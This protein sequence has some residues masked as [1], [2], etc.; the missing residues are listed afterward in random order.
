MGT[1]GMS[2]VCPNLYACCKP[3]PH[4]S[5]TDTALAL[6]YIGSP[7]IPVGQDPSRGSHKAT[8][9]AGGG[10]LGVPP[11]FSFPTGGTRGSGESLWLVL[12]WPGRGAMWSA[13]SHFPYLLVWSILVSGTGA[14][15]VSTPSPSHVLRSSQ[16]FL[17]HD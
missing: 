4:L 13:C 1:A 16:W 7:A 5:V 15:S 3:P 9:N 17:V 12:H 14:A 6:G 2:L 8:R 10:I 11:G